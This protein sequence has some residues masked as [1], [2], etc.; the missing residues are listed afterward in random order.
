MKTVKKS[1]KAAIAEGKSWN[2]ELHSFLLNYRATPRRSFCRRLIS[3]PGCDVDMASYRI[4]RILFCARGH[5]N[6]SEAR[7]FAFTCSHGDSIDTTIFQCHVFRCEIPEAVGKVL[8]SFANAF[9]RVPRL[10]SSGPTY[11]PGDPLFKFEVSLEVK[12]EDGKGSYAVC[13]KD[14]SCFKLRRNLEKKLV[15]SVQQTAGFRELVIERCFGLLISPGRN[16]KNSDM[17]LLDMVAMGTA[18]EGK[19][20]VISGVWNPA[21]HA[22]DVLNT[23]TSKDTRVFMTVA[24]D[25]V[26]VGIQEPVRFIVE[27]KAKIFPQN[28]R[29]WYY[30]K[31]SL[32]EQFFLKL[33]EDENSGGS[34]EQ[35]TYLVVS[36]E[37]ATDIERRK[38]MLPLSTPHPPA[39]SASTGSMSTLGDNDDDS[40]ADEPL[41]S[42]SGDVSKDCTEGELEDWAEVLSRWHQNLKQRPSKLTALVRRG[43]P[44]ALRGEVW[45]LLAGC[46]H[47]EE[48]EM[49]ESYRI[50]ITNDSPCEQVIARDI[51]R[52]FP[53]HD[54]FKEAGGLGQD[55][56]FKLS[57]AYSVYDEEI[58]YCQG[59]SFLA[60]ALLLHIPEEQAFC[61]LVKIM[62]EYGHRNIFRQNFEEL[63]LKFY[64]LERL[65]EVGKVLMSFANAFR[66]VPRL[67]SSGPTYSPGDPLFKFEVSLEVKEEDGKGSYAVCPKDKSCFKLRRN[68]EKKLVLSVQQTAGFRELVIER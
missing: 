63:H 18:A 13:P 43:I 4:H 26:I 7:C 21:D 9:R 41:M 11:S 3:E 6:S 56:L 36:I 31:R 55:S 14:K 58:G 46:T 34:G 8:M 15:L 20:Y 28:E 27:T 66:R 42:G 19:Q 53:A 29:F 32:T 38:S 24:V 35:H 57:K 49:F 50:L 59:Q 25:L 33:K 61:I 60:A 47:D 1:I 67:P 30:A 22:F 44:E 17:H 52:T 2:Q 40:D 65:I 48:Q 68:L 62:F 12:E 54:F 5:M 23:E 16:V 45:Q 10:P 37:S 51:H 64:Q 39:T